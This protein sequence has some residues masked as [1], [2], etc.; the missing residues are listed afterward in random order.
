MRSLDDSYRILLSFFIEPS[1]KVLPHAHNLTGC[2]SNTSQRV[3][4]LGSRTRQM[5]LR[6]VPIRCVPV[7]GI[8]CLTLAM[9]SC[10]SALWTRPSCVA[11]DPIKCSFSPPVRP[12]DHEQFA[13]SNAAMTLVSHRYQPVTT[14]VGKRSLTL[15]DCRAT[16]LANNL[17]VH[18]AR[19]EDL[20][21]AAM[22]ESNRTKMLPRMLFYAD[23]AQKDNQIYDYNDVLGQEGRPPRIGSIGEGKEYKTSKE[24][25]T[26]R[27]VLEARWNVTDAALAYYLSKSTLNNKLR[28]HHQKVRIAQKLIAAV[29]QAHFRLLSLQKSLPVAEELVY[30]RS[31]IARDT[32]KLAEKGALGIVECDKARQ[33]E[34]RAERILSKIR[35]EIERQRDILSSAMGLSP[36]NSI[37]GGFRVSGTLF[38]P[39]LKASLCDLEMQAVRNRPEAL[40]AGLTHINSTNELQRTMIKSFP[41]L[42]VYWKYTRD[43]NKYLYRKD[44]KE[45]GAYV[46]FDLMEWFQNQGETKAARAQVAATHAK[47]GVVA[48]GIASQVRVA[49]V[50][51]SDA[52]SQLRSVEASLKS[53]EQVWQA[54]KQKAPRDDPDKIALDEARATILQD[55]LDRNKALGEVN[56]RLAELQGAMGTN[57]SEPPPCGQT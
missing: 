47:M 23:L 43:Q 26:W 40:D 33:K 30:L 20:T 14:V 4:A 10:Q 17:K 48:L 7:V 57:Y 34:I 36:D 37:D 53:T 42:K 1:L 19:L 44:W 6:R 12:A 35:H 39:S 16:A 52:M 46:Y 45:I 15:D 55:T 18:V 3:P 54:L 5:T 25:G 11:A 8:L 51:Y 24:R 27:Y 41:K 49:A 29:D 31:K 22:A 38:A 13:S 50:D 2:L 32:R 56:A 28:E 9:T 21:K